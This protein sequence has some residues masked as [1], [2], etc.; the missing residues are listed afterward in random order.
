MNE[1]ELINPS[2]PYTFLA[3][4]RETAALVVLL[5]SAAYG[6]HQKNGNDDTDIP[7]F[8]FGGAREWF[9]EQFGHTT[10][11]GFENNREAVGKALLSFVLGGFEDRRR[12]DVALD[13]I[14][15]NGKK[16]EF[17]KQWQDARS[18]VND[19]GTYAHSLG[20][21]ILESEG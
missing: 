21:K 13:A 7:I 9:Q 1:Y 5:L 16:E 2:D 8:I 6:A 10:D 17:I 19:I 20:K 11:Q 14:T 12:Y 3:E 4:S 15:E 18:S